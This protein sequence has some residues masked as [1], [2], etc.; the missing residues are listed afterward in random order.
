M[1]LTTFVIALLFIIALSNLLDSAFPTLPLS[2]IQIGLGALIALTPINIHINLQP[3]IFLGILIAPLLYREA[4]EADLSSLWKVR[5]EVV[6]LVFGLVFVTVIV[7]GF[8]ADF[9]LATVPLAACFCLGGILGPTDPV[10]VKSVYSRI[11]INDN[12]M[13]ILKGESL[14]NDASGVIAFSFAAIALTTGDFPVAEMSLK[15]IY[16]CIA[17]VIVGLAIVTLKNFILR[18]LRHTRVQNSAAFMI[19]EMLVPFICFFIAQ[20]IGASGILAAVAAGTRQALLVRRVEIFEARFAVIKR[21]LWD[22]VKGIFNSFI[23][24]LLGLELPRIVISVQNDVGISVPYAMKIAALVTC[25]LFAVRYLGVVIAAREKHIESVRERRRNQAV[26]TLSGVK[27]TV[28]LATAFALPAV[29]SDGAFFIERDLLL[30]IT[31]CVII[32]SLVIANVV[33]PFIAKARVHKEKNEGRIT[34]LKEVIER[35]ESDGSDHNEAVVMR[36]KRRVLELELED[37]GKREMR[38]YR[39]IRNEFFNREMLLLEKKYLDG[40]YTREEY[41]TYARVQSLL[42]EIQNDSVL[43]RYR[44]RM[45]S[46]L[47][48]IK[49]KDK[50]EDPKKERNNIARV[51]IKRVHE[52][53]WE[54]TSIVIQ[55]L[56]DE[57]E[58]EGKDLRLFSHVVEER[59]ESARTVLRYVSDENTEEDP[60]ANIRNYYELKRSYDIERDVIFE[61]LEDGRITEEEADDLRVQ[62]N[63][64]ENFTIEEMQN[65]SATKLYISGRRLNP[66]ERRK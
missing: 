16:M 40:E 50:R 51:D 7:I 47:R 45:M 64:L 20:E 48:S 8:S 25:V 28:S 57:E 32:Y 5:K 6:F 38:R 1:A 35:I 4:E 52:I 49:R 15:F 26:L 13:N 53:F 30:L 63:T 58:Y 3:E 39:R 21:S 29:I 23:F 33:L 37:R 60:N 9:F 10:A 31:A 22:M 2:L 55:T 36:L 18:S 62:I 65:D 59:L 24:I 14:I 17:G 66:S 54:I 11:D 44:H 12:D 61:F 34:V 41:I 46:A 19:I 42:G 27:G 43:L 56:E